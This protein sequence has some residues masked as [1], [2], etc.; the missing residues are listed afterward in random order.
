LTKLVGMNAQLVIVKDVAGRL[1]LKKACHSSGN[2][3]FVTS[4]KAFDL[5]KKGD[6]GLLPIGFRAENVFLYEGQ[7]I[8]RTLNW[9]TLKPFLVPGTL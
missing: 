8:D 9:K 4:E 1:L 7:K 6:S 3:V 2:I 5:I